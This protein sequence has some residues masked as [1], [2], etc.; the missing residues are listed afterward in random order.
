MS[1]INKCQSGNTWPAHVNRNIQTKENYFEVE[2][3]EF[4]SYTW[5][6]KH[7]RKY[8]DKKYCGPKTIFSEN[9]PKFN[10]QPDYSNQ[11]GVKFYLELVPNGEDEDCQEF[12]S[13][14]LY[15]PSCIKTDVVLKYQICIIDKNQNKCNFEGNMPF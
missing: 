1:F 4:F 14:F 9:F 2:H 11:L 3:S 13:I 5:S 15:L 7:V 6:I 10:F 8:F 12:V